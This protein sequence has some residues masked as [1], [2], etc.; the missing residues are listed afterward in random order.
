M[1]F[2][3]FKHLLDDLGGNWF[4]HWFNL[5][6][7]PTAK[8]KD[9]NPDLAGRGSWND[10]ILPYSNLRTTCLLCLVVKW[11][12]SCRQIERTKPTCQA[13]Y[14]KNHKS[15]VIVLFLLILLTCSEFDRSES[16]LSWW[17]LLQLGSGFVLHLVEDN[18]LFVCAT[19]SSS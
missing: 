12:L 7:I 6:H 3:F 15:L 2:G 4:I 19:C 11:H 18:A 13:E 17:G 14:H 16:A 5:I 8:D 1:I 9:E 10:R